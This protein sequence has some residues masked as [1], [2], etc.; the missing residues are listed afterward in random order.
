MDFL[1]LAVLNPSTFTVPED[2]PGTH[3]AWSCSLVISS[4]SLQPS[5]LL[6]FF[7]S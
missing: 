4:A 3:G 2:G 6:I 5:S 7:S 1:S